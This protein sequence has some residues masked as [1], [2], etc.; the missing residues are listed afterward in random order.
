MPQVK[1]QL[2]GQPASLF[3]VEKGGE[4]GDFAWTALMSAPM[5]FALVDRR[6]RCVFVNQRLASMNR[7][8]PQAAKGRALRDVLG[9]LADTIE[10]LLRQVLETG[11][12]VANV[13]ISGAA[14]SGPTSD[15]GHWLVNY[16]PVKDKNGL[17]S[18]VAVMITDITERT[19]AEEA[20][21]KSEE[22]IRLLLE[23]TAEAIYGIDLEGNCTFANPACLRLLGYTDPR[24]LIG[25][26][27][28]DTIHHSR[29]DGTPLPVEQC[30][31]FRAFREGEGFHA[32]DEVLWRADGSS[33][34]AEY[35]SY[36]QRQNGRVVGAVVTFL[37]ITARK[38]TEEQ[39]KRQQ[40]TIRE[41]LT[42]VLPVSEGLLIVPLIGAVNSQRAR[43]LTE[44]LLRSIRANRAKVAVLDITGVSTMDTVV[45]NHLVQTAAACRL[46]G[47]QV[48]LTG[49]SR[50][51]AQTLVTLGVDL[52]KLRTMGD[53]QSG[54]EEAHRL[55]H[56][57][58]RR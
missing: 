6:L 38:R 34:Y 14:P 31:I 22:R 23:S 53:L 21:R 29:P 37:D 4:P 12:P 19:Q 46:L 56:T 42:P 43:Q 11:E 30:R 57:E 52:S 36:P 24:Q 17:I 55:L 18:G 10:P 5:G 3:L 54:I 13:E 45:A 2:D 27:M 49:I 44:Q 32:E 20:A 33:F 41:L 35:R 28:H 26:N 39:L 48:I 47:A 16:C 9:E 1:R 8:S 40:E 58:S 25:K 50:P 7:I 51:I 15:I